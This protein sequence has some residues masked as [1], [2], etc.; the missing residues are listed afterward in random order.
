MVSAGEFREDLFYR[1]NVFPLTLPP[2]RERRDDIP[3]LSQYFARR[4]S[5]R[6]GRPSCSFSAAALAR[7]SGY[8]WPGNIREL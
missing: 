7:L 3:V 2:L 1:L 4:K 5:A 6:L 8:S